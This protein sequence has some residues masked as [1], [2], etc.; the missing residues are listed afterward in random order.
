MSAASGSLPVGDYPL[1]LA[2]S[3]VK[4][5]DCDLIRSPISDMRHEVEIDVSVQSVTITSKTIRLQLHELDRT[6]LVSRHATAADAAA[7]QLAG[8][9]S[10]QSLVVLV[11][12]THASRPLQN[13]AIVL[14]F[15][16][17]RQADSLI[18]AIACIGGDNGTLHSPSGRAAAHSDH[19]SAK[20]ML[21]IA[22]LDRSWSAVYSAEEER[23]AQALRYAA[24]VEAHRQRRLSLLSKRHN[25]VAS[26]VRKVYSAEE[27]RRL[28]Y[29]ARKQRRR[30]WAESTEHSVHAAET[31]RRDAELDAYHRRIDELGGLAPL[32]TSNRTMTS[33]AAVSHRERLWQDTQSTL[34]DSLFFSPI[35]GLNLSA[36]MS[37]S[38]PDPIYPRR[39]A[40]YADADPEGFQRLVQ[41][42]ELAGAH[43]PQAQHH[44]HK[45]QR[46]S[47]HR[48]R[49]CLRSLP[50]ISAT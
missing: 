49:S 47:V 28:V 12:A 29:S 23:N 7:L 20:A 3:R 46:R 27:Q 18:T 25:L 48:R 50:L 40:T 45:R 15:A 38:S 26:D 33:N 31:A 2:A 6:N 17:T 11:S 44:H 19:T 30:D 4:I 21:S 39:T 43:A 8:A 22:E 13:V 9:T 32:P 5:A 24:E 42:I 35:G 36:K 37:Q 41:A 10:Q 1:L 14:A 16:S 34:R